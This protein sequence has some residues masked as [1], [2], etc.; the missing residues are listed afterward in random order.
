MG[1]GSTGTEHAAQGRSI[2]SDWVEVIRRKEMEK[3][4]RS[5]WIWKNIAII[6]GVLALLVAAVVVVPQFLAAHRAAAAVPAPP[7]GAQTPAPAF[8]ADYDT[9]LSL[10]AD[11]AKR[12]DKLTKS[13]AYKAM[14]EEQDRANGMATRLTS[15]VPQGYTFDA[16]YR[17]FLLRAAP[18]APPVPTPA[19]VPPTLKQ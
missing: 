6:V 14:L 9:F 8:L 11:V 19:P 18:P 3:E 10:S 4:Y 17:A 5:E 12:Q 1:A 2:L 7:A 13:G 15:Q 16:K